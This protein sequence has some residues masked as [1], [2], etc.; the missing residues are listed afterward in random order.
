ML[1]VHITNDSLSIGRHCR[2]SFQ[3]TLRIP[4]DGKVYPLPPGLGRFPIHRISDFRN[5]VPSSWREHGGVFLPIYQREALWLSFHGAHWRPNAMKVG[6]GKINAITGKPLSMG[7]DERKQDYLVVPD[8]PWLDGI[9][10]ANGLVRQFVAMPLGQGYTVEGQL[11]GKE[12]FGGIQ[13]I[14]FDPK[15]GKFPDREPHPTRMYEMCCCM[16][17]TGMGVAAGGRITQKVYTDEYG[18]ETWDA[19]NYGRVYV[20]LVNSMMYREITGMEPPATPITARDYAR[21]GYPWFELYDEHLQD[22][23]WSGDLAGVHSVKEVDTDKGFT[24]QQDDEPVDIDPTQ[25]KHLGSTLVDDGK[26]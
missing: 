26:W 1:S 16:P 22:V 25:I 9:K 21:H 6:I 5:R 20:H 12:E 23:S 17:A 15:P 10:S 8:Q 14:V 3:R 18:R 11:T 24:A 13:L 7:F 2:V 19:T 4:D